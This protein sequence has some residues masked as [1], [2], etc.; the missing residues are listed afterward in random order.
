MDYIPDVQVTRVDN[1]ALK[2]RSS[3]QFLLSVNDGLKM[4]G[5]RSPYDLKLIIMFIKP[6][7]GA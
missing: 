7:N 1:S 4:L 5:Q 6:Y 2:F 3:Y